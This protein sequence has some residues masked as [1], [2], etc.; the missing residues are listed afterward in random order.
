MK[1]KTDFHLGFDGTRPNPYH[2]ACLLARTYL[3][4]TDIM[5]G[6]AETEFWVPLPGFDGEEFEL[7]ET[8]ELR[9]GPVQHRYFT[10]FKEIYRGLEAVRKLQ[11]IKLDLLREAEANASVKIE[12]I[13]KAISD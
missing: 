11:K 4:G 6:S 13:R 7:E 8:A 2:K 5:V 10:D 12:E 1:L 9:I 3:V